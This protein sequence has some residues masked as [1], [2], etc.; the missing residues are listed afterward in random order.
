MIPAEFGT[1]GE[2]PGICSSSPSGT[3]S[4]I[5][6]GGMVDTAGDGV[7]YKAPQT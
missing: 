5:R 7:K 2:N 3:A 1:A 6:I 4:H